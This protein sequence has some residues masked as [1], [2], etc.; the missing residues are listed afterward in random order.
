MK[1]RR[2]TCRRDIVSNVK[3]TVIMIDAARL[4]VTSDVTSAAVVAR[5]AGSRVS[6]VVALRTSQH[7]H[8]R[9]HQHSTVL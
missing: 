3:H 1:M 9:S 2:R 4:G 5:D 7:R 6:V 8:Y